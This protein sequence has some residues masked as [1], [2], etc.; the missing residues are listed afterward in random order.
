MAERDDSR[1]SPSLLG[2]L[3][4]SPADQAAWGE[5]VERYG[6]KV[7]SWCRQWGVQEADAEDVTQNVLV[8]MVRQMRS[9][10]Y[11]PTGSFRAWLRTVAYRAWCDLVAARKAVGSGDPQVLDLLNSAPAREDL[12]RRLDELC[13][14]ELL[15]LAVRHVQPRVEPQTWEAFRLTA[16]ERQPGAEVAA[17][18]GMQVAAVFKARSRVQK[19]LQGELRRLEAGGPP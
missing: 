3:R 9:F 19:M 18:L 15:E 5:F 6:R 2:R 11:R 7:Y 8:D 12:L 16:L 10:E 13:E 17:R 4:D 1:T 14:Q